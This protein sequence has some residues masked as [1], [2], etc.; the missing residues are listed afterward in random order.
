MTNEAIAEEAN[1]VLAHQR[2][3]NARYP[4]T[5]AEVNAE[6]QQIKGALIDIGVPAR[7]LN[8]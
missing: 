1:E 6:W 8:D 7:L 3:R 5:I 2:L 4:D